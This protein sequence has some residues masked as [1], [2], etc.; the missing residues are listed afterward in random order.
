ME[1]E[2]NINGIT[3]VRK[4][5]IGEDQRIVYEQD[6]EGNETKTIIPEGLTVTV[7]PNGVTWSV[8]Y[9]YYCIE[10]DFKSKE[11][12]YAYVKSRSIDD[13]HEIKAR[14]D[15]ASSKRWLDSQ[16]YYRNLFGDK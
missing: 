15:A 8:F 5:S 14:L 1:K 10:N 11:D 16:K 7:N 9:D 6:S 13:I 12:A 4:D 3:Y 2:I